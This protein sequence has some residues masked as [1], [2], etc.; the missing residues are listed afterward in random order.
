MKIYKITCLL[1]LALLVNVYAFT[2]NIKI[3]TNQVGY[4]LHAVKHAVIVA[5]HPG[6]LKSFELIN[7]DEKLVFTGECVYAG[8][9]DQWKNWVFY[10]IDF[11]PVTAKGSYTLR[12]ND[13][14]KTITSYPFIIDKNV[15][16]QYTL[17][18]IIYYFKGQRSS[19]LFDKADS[20]IP[21]EGQKDSSTVDVQGGW[22]D[23]T[24]DYGIHLSHLSFSTYFNPQQVSLTAWALLK[25]YGLLNAKPGTDFRQYKRHVL[26]EAL[27]GADFLRRMQVKNGSFYR[28]IA[29][30]GPGK[31]AKDRVIGAESKKYTIKKSKDGTFAG[32]DNEEDW[33]SFQCSYRSGGGVAIAALAL[34]STFDTSGDF[35]NK[36]YLMAAENAFAFLEKHSVEMTN[37]GKENMLDDYCAL[38]AATELYKATKKLIYQVAANNRAEKLMSRLADWKNY[39]GYWR[40]ADTDRPFFHAADAGLPLV[41]LLNYYPIASAAMQRQI[42]DVTR[43]SVEHEL[44]IT[45]E[46]NNPF[47]YSRQ[48]VQDTSG[49]RYSSF[50][51]P[52]A[53]ETAP[54]WQGENAR[55]GSMAAAARMAADLFTG[56]TPLHDS[57]ESFATDQLNWILG[58]NPFDACMLEGTGHNNVEYGFFGTFEYT[59]A[60]GGI[61]NGITSGLD[62]EHDIDLN[63]SYAQTGKDYDWRWSEQWL[64]HATW[65]MLAVALHDDQ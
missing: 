65:Y 55:L 44:R 3:V 32:G 61:V 45:H 56:D 42:K 57:L 59:N 30:P 38:L 62:N 26:D 11:T 53:T 15:L 31:L 23:A 5:G 27:F 36:Q 41:S 28:S 21:F 8:P 33:K 40:V 50:F 7:A 25:T 29:A 35:T 2:Q 1:F 6:S 48:L 49:N 22:Y 18:D 64:P 37:D 12:V 54:W 17:S 43:R 51:F 16:E 9:V 10:T 24:G 19:G 4:D 60:P 47:G 13:S 34:A 52:H 58:L 63:V 46:V 39:T 14:G 20:H